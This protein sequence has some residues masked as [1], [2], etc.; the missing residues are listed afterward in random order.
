MRASHHEHAH[1]RSRAGSSVAPMRS[2]SSRASDSSSRTGAACKQ[3]LSPPTA[4]VHQEDSKHVANMTNS[5]ARSIFMRTSSA[6]ASD[7][8]TRARRLASSGPT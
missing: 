5:C 7:S 8:V 2:H 6:R 4:G 3:S 1:A